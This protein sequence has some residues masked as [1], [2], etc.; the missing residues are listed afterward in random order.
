MSTLCR[1]YGFNQFYL[2]HLGRW[3]S[4]DLS[5][6]YMHIAHL[7]VTFKLHLLCACV[8]ISIDGTLEE[9]RVLVKAHLGVVQRKRLQT[10][11]I[12]TA[13]YSSCS[14]DYDRAMCHARRLLTTGVWQL[15]VISGMHVQVDASIW[16][17]P[18]SSADV[19]QV[20]IKPFQP[21]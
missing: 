18:V 11:K 7:H 12:I 10:S 3:F 21:G 16:M 14:R 8:C 17:E 2:N 1:R 13:S 5:S 6:L 9:T 20:R 4:T 15:R 19:S